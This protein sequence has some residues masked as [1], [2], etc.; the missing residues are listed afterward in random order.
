[1]AYTQGQLD[2]LKSALASGALKV[3]FEGREITYR[4]I[5]ELRKAIS[6]VSAGLVTETTG[7]RRSRVTRVFS[8]KGFDS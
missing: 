1:M 5:D 4:S 6:D 3:F 2:A 8:R 7:T